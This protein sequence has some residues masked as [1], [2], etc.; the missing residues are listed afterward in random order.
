MILKKASKSRA[1]QIPPFEYD[2]IECLETNLFKSEKKVFYN[3]KVDYV[4]LDLFSQGILNVFEE[5]E[6]DDLYFALE[7]QI[8]EA[9]AY[10]ENLI[11]IIPCIPDLSLLITILSEITTEGAYLNNQYPCYGLEIQA[12]AI[13][14]TLELYIIYFGN[15]FKGITKEKTVSFLSN[16]LNKDSSFVNNIPNINHFLG[17]LSERIGFHQIFKYVLEAEEHRCSSSETLFLSF[18]DIL[19]DSGTLDKEE[20]QEILQEH[21]EK[22]HPAPHLKEETYNTLGLSFKK[23]MMRATNSKE[24]LFLREKTP[25]FDSLMRK[26]HRRPYEKYSKKSVFSTDNNNSFSSYTDNNID[27]GSIESNKLGEGSLK[28]PT[29][30]REKSI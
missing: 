2:K 11:F 16:F 22:S 17:H 13:G 26:L 5:L 7:N 10:S 19:K 23:N 4:I 9:F 1:L 18:L 21:I 12:I 6:E 3:A 8:N 29:L 20:Q 30:A 15:R 14:A 25:D 24:C 28:T 27:L